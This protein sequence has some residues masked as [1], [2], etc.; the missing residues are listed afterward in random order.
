MQGKTWGSAEGSAAEGSGFNSCNHLLIPS[1]FSSLGVFKCRDI[2][3][4]TIDDAHIQGGL[5]RVTLTY[6][7]TH[8]DGR[9]PAGTAYI[10][11]S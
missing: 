2:A 6:N 3:A 7:L 5:R 10:A 4:D 8:A 11:S 1:L 9:C